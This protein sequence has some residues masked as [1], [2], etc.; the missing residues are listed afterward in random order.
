MDRPLTVK[1][2]LPMG[3]LSAC[4]WGVRARPAAGR[5]R[6][7]RAEGWEPGLAAALL[8]GV[9]RVPADILVWV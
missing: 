6:G 4:K 2:R 3:I 8:V 5:A 1:A 9:P 7:R